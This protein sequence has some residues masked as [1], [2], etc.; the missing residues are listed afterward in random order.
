MRSLWKVKVRRSPETE[1]HFQTFVRWVRKTINSGTDGTVSLYEKYDEAT[2]LENQ[3][4]FE[5]DAYLTSLEA[6][7]EDKGDRGSAMSFFAKLLK[8]LRDQMKASGDTLP[9]DRR[10][11]VAK[12]QRAWEATLK[13]GRPN[14]NQ[15]AKH[16]QRSCSPRH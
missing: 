8:L 11:M 9:E 13:K 10:Q 12:A 16:R 14:Q 6:L 2:Q 1:A 5:F 15:S 3:Y 4:P 7:M